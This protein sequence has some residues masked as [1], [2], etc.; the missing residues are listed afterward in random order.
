MLSYSNMPLSAP[1]LLWL[2][3]AGL[4][5]GPRAAEDPCLSAYLPSFQE[6]LELGAGAWAEKCGSGLSADEILQEAR[7]RHRRRHRRQGFSNKTGESAGGEEES[8]GLGNSADQLRNALDSEDFEGL[9]DNGL[10]KNEVLARAPALPA[11]SLTLKPMPLERAETR[12]EERSELRARL[13]ASSPLDPE[14]VEENFQYYPGPSFLSDLPGPLGWLGSLIDNL[15]V[16]PIRSLF[17]S[18]EERFVR[19]MLGGVQHS[20]QAREVMRDLIAENKASGDTVTISPIGYSGSEIVDKD[21]IQQI[22]GAPRGQ[23]DPREGIY[24][25]NADIMELAAA[26]QVLGGNMIHEFHHILLHKK[27]KRLIP[28]HETAFYFALAD[29]KRARLKGFITAWQLNDGNPNLYT[30]ESRELIADAPGYWSRMKLWNPVYAAGLDL[31]EMQDPVAAYDQRI[32]DLQ[33]MEKELRAAVKVLPDRIARVR[34]LG[35]KHVP[36]ESLRDLRA[37]LGK[38]QK[39]LPLEIQSAQDSIDAVKERLKLLDPNDKEGQELL[40]ALRAAAQSEKYRKIVE[41]L[42]PDIDTLARLSTRPLADR[43]PKGQL[44]WREFTAAWREYHVEDTWEERGQ[45]H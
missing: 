35:E 28:E 29:E 16:R 38:T 9:Y 24:Y 43:R 13:E 40:K 11:V 12:V 31:A 10:A 36:A 6:D 21:G 42:E 18:R 27:V 45:A 3:L 7:G 5:P 33:E 23:A 32:L 17:P 41:E 8:S 15:I 19:E 34:H 44:N 30:Q 14:E 2:F 22:E 1:L 20:A 39:L 37:L 26:D 25:F 4:A